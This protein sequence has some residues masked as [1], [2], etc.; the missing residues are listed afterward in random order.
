MMDF[1]QSVL[2]E[3]WATLE[4][5][6]PYLLFGFAVAGALSV[7]LPAE[8][9]ERHLGGRGL[10]PVVRASLFGIPLPLCSCG[11]IPV[12]TSL[13][14]HG[15]SRGATV[16]F[17]LST[18]QTGVDSILATYSLLGP[19]FAIFRP[20]AAFITGVLGGWLTERFETAGEKAA[21]AAR[22]AEACEDD[23]CAHKQSHPLLRGLRFGFYTLPRDIG[24]AMLIGI[25]IAG[26]IAALVPDDF[27][28]GAL[29]TGF[30]GMLVM[31]LLGIPT[32]VCATASI[33]IAAALMAK[34]VSPGA[35]LVFLVTGP[36]TNAAAIATIWKMMGRRTAFV[37]LA[38]IAFSAL[39]CGFLLDFL[40]TAAKIPAGHLHH[41]MATP[42]LG[43]ASA[44]LLLAIL[45]FANLWSAR[46]RTRAPAA[47]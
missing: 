41:A 46:K 8:T 38:T 15:A 18:P 10:G 1:M 20:V 40:F 4:Q 39:L 21:E 25:L 27:F 23:C 28:A 30:L 3:G 42:W 45:A 19:V 36:A 37:Y 17:L 29:G 22:T 11:V 14:K 31:M 34:G 44:I 12:A 9:V 13:R 35:A 47:R 6:A 43:T 16:S 33:P 5:M 32:Y 26:L 7:M 2:R 24:Q